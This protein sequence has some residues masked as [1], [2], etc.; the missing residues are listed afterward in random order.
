MPSSK[1]THYSRETE[2]LLKDR[3]EAVIRGDIEGFEKLS[4]EFKASKTNDK[5]QCVIRS[6]QE[7]MDPREKWM[8]IKN[9][10]RDYNPSHITGQA[11]QEKTSLQIKQ[12]K[13]SPDTW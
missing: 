13:R 8:G 7:D 5:K 9:P 11:R 3:G 4:K 12:Q 10:R 1:D 6:I 2:R